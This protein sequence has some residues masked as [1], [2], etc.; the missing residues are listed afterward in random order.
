MEILPAIDLLAGRVVR[1]RQGSYDQPTHY[2]DD[3]AEVA[4]AFAAAGARWIHMVDLDAARTGKRTNQKAIAAVRQAVGLKLQVGGGARD[5]DSVGSILDQG[6]DRVVVG[7]AALRDWSWF[8]RLVDRSG[9][10]GRIALGLDAR[11]GHLAVH[12]W[13]EQMTATPLEIIRRVQGWPLGAVVYTD[14]GRDGMQGGINLEQTRL[15]VDNTNLPVIASGGLAGIQDVLECRRIGCWGVIIGRAYYEGNID[16][17][18]A[19]KAAA[20]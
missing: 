15:L 4:R 18:E 17:A 12:G 9:L 20:E 3:P 13:T 7:S 5:D 19:V 6:V 1:L 14:I 10:A 2:S 11:S 16:L 8:R